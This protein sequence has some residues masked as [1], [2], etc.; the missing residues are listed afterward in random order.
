[1]GAGGIEAIVCGLSNELA[2]AH[3]VT[4]CTL[5][6]PIAGEVFYERLSPA[7]RKETIGK[8]EAT[9]PVKVV[10]Q[11]Y[12]YL[13]KSDFEVVHIHSFFYFYA[14]AV[15]LLHRKKRFFYTVHSDASKENMPWDLRLLAFKR[16]CFR[17]GWVHPVT[18]SPASQASFRQLYHCN[19]SL[20]PNGIPRPVVVAG[21][22]AVPYR[23]TP[24]T[25]VFVNPG[26]IDPAKNQGMLCRVFDRLVREGH[27]V[28]LLIAGPNCKEV[29]YREMEPYFSERIRY[30]GE[31]PDIP[32]LLGGADGM[33]LSSLYEGMPVVV[34][35]AFAVGCPCIC[36]PVGGIVNMIEDG[37]NGLLSAAVSEEAYYDAMLRFLSLSEDEIA[38]LRQRTR[39]SF[40]PYDIAHMAANYY[41]CYLNE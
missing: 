40:E 22:V 35:E 34:I 9:S 18:I 17:R 10:F 38:A 3:A 33:V 11:I 39:D 12:Q 30:I 21:D 32:S 36:T 14:L 19:S 16:F 8:T 4:V 28:C 26:R 6:Q 20:I 5:R 27:D 23:L 25:R 1:M 7:V 41:Q 37:V 29:S 15:L 13:K 24:Q 31:C 2:K